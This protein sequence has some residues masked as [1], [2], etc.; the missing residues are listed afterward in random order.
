M[1]TILDTIIA[2]KQKEVNALKSRTTLVQL[3]KE[4]AG[5]PNKTRSLYASLNDGSK[6][7]IIAEF[8]RRSPSKGWFTSP[9]LEISNV[10]RAY[11]DVGASAIS[12]LTD[13]TYFGGSADDLIK[14]KA[15]V[16]VPVLRKDFMI[17][18]IQI[19]ESKAMGADVIL[20]I[21]ACLTPAQV[22]TLATYAAALG[23]EII[24][25]LHD[26]SELNHICDETTIIGINN[27]DLKTFAVDIDRSLKMAEMLP[28]GVIK[29][30][31]SGISSIENIRLF[32]KNGFKG[33]LIGEN[34]MKS[35]DPAKAFTSFVESLKSV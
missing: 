7:G 28:K 26:E 20:L 13:Q 9:D 14:T 24:L 1:N 8:K 15:I 30:A 3:E 25:E 18:A 35:L 23:L 6:T 34:F 16:Q 17:D 2:S 4:I 5:V 12:V 19:A 32:A 31:E 29:I 11:D 21:A 22:R 10:V 27:R 33:F